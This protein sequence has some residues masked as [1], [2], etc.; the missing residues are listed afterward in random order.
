MTQLTC[1]ANAVNSSF[2]L[3][4][5]LNRRYILSNCKA[6]TLYK[7]VQKHKFPW[8]YLDDG[9]LACDTEIGRYLPAFQ[10]NLLLP[11]SKTET[12]G[13]IRFLLQLYPYVT[14]CVPSHPT[15]LQR[16]L[17]K[18]SYKTVVIFKV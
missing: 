5:V 9:V 14:D 2:T 8:H 15:K 18:M 4:M 13:D 1:T 3:Q 12:G 17:Y 10:E 11:S 6:Q 7:S 16:K